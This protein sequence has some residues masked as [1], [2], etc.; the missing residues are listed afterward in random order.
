MTESALR[1]INLERGDPEI[2]QNAADSRPGKRSYAGFELR[3]STLNQVYA[4]R[5]DFPG[6]G[7]GIG[8]PVA[9][10]QPSA[11]RK[12]L[13]N[14]PAMAAAPDSSVNENALRVSDKQIY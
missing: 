5:Q 3:K 12:P 7:N 2:H 10:N 9:S 1:G 14:E 8:I 6:A 13:E 4:F 11:A